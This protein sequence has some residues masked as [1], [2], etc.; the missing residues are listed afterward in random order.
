MRFESKEAA[1]T[2]EHGGATYYFCGEG[3]KQ[4][5]EDD[6]ERYIE[7]TGQGRQPTSM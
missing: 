5:F 1:A 2:A 3:C 6:P 4:A 7:A